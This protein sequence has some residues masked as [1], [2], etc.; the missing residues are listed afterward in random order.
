MCSDDNNS[1]QQINSIQVKVCRKTSDTSANSSFRRFLKCNS[2]SSESNID[3][4]LEERL[5]FR[6][7]IPFMSAVLNMLRHFQGSNIS[8]RG[9]RRRGGWRG[10][11]GVIFAYDILFRL[12]PLLLKGRSLLNLTVWSCK[13]M[14][15]TFDINDPPLSDGKMKL[16]AERVREALK[17]RTN[18]FGPKPGNHYRTKPLLHPW[19]KQKYHSINKPRPGVI[20]KHTK[21]LHLC[22][23]I[24]NWDA[25]CLLRSLSICSWAQFWRQPRTHWWV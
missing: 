4:G 3:G 23:L 17:S 9:E 1:T 6:S 7:T 18:L 10:G 22:R 12:G 11:L 24:N 16:V 21:S 19:N 25:G 13:Q 5:C 8:W 2:T 20:N 14:R 15:K